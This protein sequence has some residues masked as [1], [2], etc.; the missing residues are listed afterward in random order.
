MLPTPRKRG[1]RLITPTV[2]GVRCVAT[3]QGRPG[4]RRQQNSPYVSQGNQACCICLDQAVQM[5]QLGSCTHLVCRGCMASHLLHAFKLAQLP[6]RCPL[7]HC[8]ARLSLQ[9]SLMLMEQQ[10]PGS[11][12]F[13]AQ[14]LLAGADPLLGIPDDMCIACPYQDC[15]VPMELDGQQLPDLPSDCPA[16]S[17]PICA[18]CR[19]TW[20]SGLCCAEYQVLAAGATRQGSLSGSGSFSSHQQ[21][22]PPLI[23]AASN[24]GST[25]RQQHSSGCDSTHYQSPKLAAA[26][27]AAADGWPGGSGRQLV[28]ALDTCDQDSMAWSPSKRT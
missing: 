27:A 15:Q 2:E 14:V 26:R 4:K 11:K 8:R 18:T 28:A 24:C 23:S 1:A 6:L 19:S 16:C 10:V 17:R 5:V 25:Q 21:Q 3:L 22:P 13:A 9:A 12:A 7:P 20:H